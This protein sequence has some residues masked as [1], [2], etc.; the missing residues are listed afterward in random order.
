MKSLEELAQ[1]IAEELKEEFD[2]IGDLEGHC[3]SCSEYVN[4]SEYDLK[5]FIENILLKSV[6]EDIKKEN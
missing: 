5:K 4:T 6:E 1:F 3:R 2:M